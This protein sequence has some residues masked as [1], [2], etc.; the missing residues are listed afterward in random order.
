MAQCIITRHFRPK[1]KNNVRS[2]FDG[3]VLLHI[4]VACNIIKKFCLS[5][6]YVLKVFPGSSFVSAVEMSRQRNP[7]EMCACI[8]TIGHSCA[9]LDDVTLL[10]D[11]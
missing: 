1:V 3:G 8:H 2:C 9:S 11:I 4:S 6:R 10:C 7:P 5:N